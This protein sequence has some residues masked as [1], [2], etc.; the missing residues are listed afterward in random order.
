MQTTKSI[1]K[2]INSLLEDYKAGKVHKSTA[3][4]RMALLKTCE[5]YLVTNPREE[6]VKSEAQ[7]ITTK[8]DVLEKRYGQWCAGRTGSQGE[9]WRA[10]CSETGIN[11][12]RAQLRTLKF[13]LAD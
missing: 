12:M 8:I 9:L 2:Q 10:Y 5:N 11:T 7:A 6:F 13:L 1:K 3:V 4:K